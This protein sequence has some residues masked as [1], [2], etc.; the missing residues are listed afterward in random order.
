VVRGELDAMVWTP[1]HGRG[2]G[3]GRHGA[4]SAYLPRRRHKSRPPG[5]G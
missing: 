3:A 2:D 5:H 1:Q 4:R